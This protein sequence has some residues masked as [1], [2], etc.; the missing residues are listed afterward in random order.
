MFRR[1]IRLRILLILMLVFLV[2][3]FL[4]RL[5]LPLFNVINVIH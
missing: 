2:C 5:S 1:R 3:V 4:W